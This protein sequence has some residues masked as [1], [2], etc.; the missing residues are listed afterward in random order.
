MP[1]MT[2]LQ[3]VLANERRQFQSRTVAAISDARRRSMAI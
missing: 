2:Q 1:T 3:N